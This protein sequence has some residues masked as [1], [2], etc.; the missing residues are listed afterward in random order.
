M[1]QRHTPDGRY[2]VVRGR[3]WRAANPHL[4]DATRQALVQQLMQARRDVKS[5][6]ASR[7]AARLRQA[8]E[9]VHAAKTALGERGPVWWRDGARDYN[10]HL[11]RNTPYAGWYA[12]LEDDA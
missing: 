8:R 7:D 4:A 1:A 12:G 2:L 5:A 3:L 6:M 11:V 9:A 10:R